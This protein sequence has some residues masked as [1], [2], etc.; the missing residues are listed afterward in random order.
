MK[1][2]SFKAYLKSRLSKKEIDE[3]KQQA[4]FEVRTLQFNQNIRKRPQ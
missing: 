3:V 1:A 4:L 2:K